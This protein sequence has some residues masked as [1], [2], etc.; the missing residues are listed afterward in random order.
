LHHADCDAVQ[1]YRSI[2]ALKSVGRINRRCKPQLAGPRMFWCMTI[3]DALDVGPERVRF[4]RPDVL[5]Y[6]AHPIDLY[7]LICAL[8]L[9]A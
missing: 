5:F 9:M 6:D 7:Q 1:F 4:A 2:S 8:Y 3:S